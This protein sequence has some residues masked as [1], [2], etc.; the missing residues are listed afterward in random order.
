MLALKTMLH[1]N[2]TAMTLVFD[3]IDA[4]IGGATATAVAERLQELARTHQVIVVT[5]LAQI[6]AKANAQFVVRKETTKQGATTI[7]SPVSGQQRVA[8]IARMLSGS[9]DKTALEH[10]KQLLEGQ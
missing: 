7:I 9:T 8:E 6:A 5:H 2:E 3:E 10:A 1:S 4:G